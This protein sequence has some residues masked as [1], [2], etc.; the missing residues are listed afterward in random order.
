MQ[1]LREWA[2][3]LK[4]EIR[5]VAIA[6]RSPQTPWFAKLFAALVVA[7]ALYFVFLFR[8]AHK[9]SIRIASPNPTPW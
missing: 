3:R 9:T 2:R 1:R 8:K 7:Y 5:A 4:L 6:Y